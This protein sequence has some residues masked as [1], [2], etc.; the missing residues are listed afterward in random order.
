M[1]FGNIC[2]HIQMLSVP[3]HTH[4]KTLNKTH[5][6]LS[7]KSIKFIKSLE[8]CLPTA[9]SPQRA[10]LSQP[11]SPL[12]WKAYGA[13]PQPRN[14]SQ[15]YFISSALY[16]YPCSKA[17]GNSSVFSRAASSSPVSS[18][19]LLGVFYSSCAHTA[20]HSACSLLGS[21]GAHPINSPAPSPPCL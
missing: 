4:P 15:K 2:V 1:P 6:E 11:R 3:G 14:A 17:S 8:L 9:L 10:V 20:A 13:S 5:H 16:I 7:L 18:R 21:W 19:A 12:L